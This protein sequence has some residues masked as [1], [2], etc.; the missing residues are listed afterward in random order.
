MG[1]YTLQSVS[2]S[3]LPFMLV[4][5][6]S[7]RWELASGHLEL[8]QDGSFT[9]VLGVDVTNGSGSPASESVSMTTAGTYAV[10]E[11]GIRFDTVEYGHWLATYDGAVLVYYVGN[12]LALAFRL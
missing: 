11:D 7:E 6:L 3:P 12:G 9:E 5:N 4:Q 10:V 2:G 8:R 1:T